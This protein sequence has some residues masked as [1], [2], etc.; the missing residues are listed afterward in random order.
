[1]PAARLGPSDVV[2]AFAGVRPLASGGGDTGALDRG[3][4]VAWDEPGFLAVRGGKLTL[5]LDG[6]RQALRALGAEAAALGL[7]EIAVPPFGALSQPAPTLAATRQRLPPRPST[8]PPV[9]EPATW[10]PA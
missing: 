8:F 5:A 3:Y 2:G 1:V 9:T 7:P 10:R 4:A 6:A